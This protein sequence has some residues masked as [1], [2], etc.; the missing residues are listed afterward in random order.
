MEIEEIMCPICKYPYN[1]NEKI[2][3]LLF[4][5]G[6]TICQECILIKINLNDKN[7][8]SQSELISS[9]SPIFQC[10]EDNTTYNEVKQLE[11]FP[12]NVSLLKLI[13]KNEEKNK[14]IINIEILPINSS[15]N[16]IEN[17]NKET[18]VNKEEDHSSVNVNSSKQT[19][20]ENI[21][22]LPFQEGTSTHIIDNFRASLKKSSNNTDNNNLLQISNTNIKYCSLHPTRPLETIYKCEDSNSCA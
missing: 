12:K 14:K 2:P 8:L 3:R 16:S 11:L 21:K 20:C 19:I 5:C 13:T 10:Q 22:T 18:K 1:S 4:K 9:N 6:H 17:H 15:S 7:N